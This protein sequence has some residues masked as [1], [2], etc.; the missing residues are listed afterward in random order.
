MSSARRTVDPGRRRNP[1][2]SGNGRLLDEIEVLSD[3]LCLNKPSDPRSK[4]HSDLSRSKSRVSNKP[5]KKP[6]SS[7]AASSIWNW[8]LKAFLHHRSRRFDIRFTL[9]VH[10]I[11]DLPPSFNNLGVRVHWRRGTS[12][13]G[14]GLQTRPVKVFQCVAEFEEALNYRC[15]VHGTRGG[16]SG[17]LAKYEA[18]PFS[19]HASLAAAS[20]IDLGRHRIDLTRLLPLMLEELEEEKR[21]RR[22]TTSFNLSGK[23]KGAVLNVS[24]G[25]CVVGD[26]E[27]PDSMG[28]K[29]KT[30]HALN[31][32][33][34]VRRAG[35]LP[36]MDPSVEDHLI[37]SRHLPSKSFG[38][39][40]V[41]NEALPVSRSDGLDMIRADGERVGLGI[42]VASKLAEAKSYDLVELPVENIID[43]GNNE[44]NFSVIEQGIENTMKDELKFEP[45]VGHE[46]HDGVD[47]V[48]KVSVEGGGEE[49]DR[50]ADQ[51]KVEADGVDQKEDSLEEFSN[52]E[53]E[54]LHCENETKEARF[55]VDEMSADDIESTFCSPRA[56]VVTPE[57]NLE[58]TKAVPDYKTGRVSK[59]LSL[60]EVVDTVADEF[61]SML[62]IEQSTFSQ[63]SESDTDSPKERLWKQFTRESLGGCDAMFGLDFGSEGNEVR[64]DYE[65]PL[66][67]PNWGDL[68]EDFGLSSLIQAAEVDH[69][70]MGSKT[71]AKI[72]EDAETESLMHEWGLNEKAFESSPLE[73]ACG[74]G[75]PSDVPC[76]DPFGLP[77]LGEDLGPFIQT[78]DGGFLRSM[79]PTL[80]N[81][82]KNNGSLIMQVSR[83]VV[84]PAE[85]GSGI[86]E[87]LQRLASV[88]IE[89]LS[90]QAS[91]LMPLEDIMG[92]TMQQLAWEVSP[93][94]EACERL[95]ISHPK[96][97]AEDGFMQDGFGGRKK[98]KGS[99][100]RFPKMD[101]GSSGGDMGS[102]YVS[103]EDLAPLAM[104]KI[105]ALSMEG[106]RIQSGMSD[107]E[108][109]SNISP[110]SIGEISALEGLG[111]RTSGS[112]G[113]EGTA[114]LQLMDIKESCNDVDGLMGLSLTL[115]E[116]MRIDSGVVDEE[117]QTSER[118]SKILAAHHAK[119]TEF[120]GG[121]KK[122][123][124][125]R[126]KGA[127]RRWGLLGNNFT[128]A[129]MVQLRD[130]LRNYEPVGTPMLALMQVERVFV[131]PKPKIYSTVSDKGNTEEP[132]ES[133][134][135]LKP[136][137]LEKVEKVEK[138]EI[139]PQFKITEVHV[140]GLKT[141]PG[142][143]KLWGNP[144]QQQSGS[145]WLLASGMGK[146]NKHPFMKSK[147]VT[148]PSQVT[149][150]M[151]PGDTLWS[152]SSRVNGDGAKWKELALLNPHIRNPNIIF[153]NQTIRL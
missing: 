97:E 62:G 121:G 107:E 112:L 53:K 152:I 12:D 124:K 57:P 29:P 86:M 102:E 69:Q 63:S 80:F 15:S 125:R 110:Q 16:G 4:V 43:N 58:Y 2:E 14:G 104:D 66:A 117:D 87:I 22:W 105:E 123:D 133:E 130:P 101:M 64:A 32:Q 50:T 78:K 67:R 116:W 128:V 33:G 17:R 39:F 119:S 129:L 141:E 92:K 25:F 18:R 106:L 74:F 147:A 28:L 13:S 85:M 38:D 126:G 40:K 127:G 52:E 1:E 84:V 135:D 45:N 108:A 34:S 37:Q 118:T 99:S 82:A 44:P 83:P 150:T 23:A 90:M 7:S 42:L 59:Y 26:D 47:H 146:S 88:G 113:L 54:F 140:A 8:P 95:G 35:S 21:S 122:G 91:K 89:K 134:S 3:A 77:S 27:T 48:V 60:D 115:D 11:D 151:Q 138:E 49:V 36:V 68:P 61:L 51:G 153:P 131:P 55:T 72:L 56:R 111:A 93:T 71:R 103:L 79:N 139:I 109:P 148:K 31:M 9:Y 73:S 143:K 137:P 142:K 149:T 20:E 46:K 24:F 75:S 41:F 76:R 94:L 70:A 10:S 136:T 30:K 81:N 19:V 5:A 145:R 144:K 98:G 120:I 114:G 65:A 132:A 100:R 6:S 96:P